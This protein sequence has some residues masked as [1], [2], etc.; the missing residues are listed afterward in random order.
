[1]LAV[2]FQQMW[3]LPYCISVVLVVQ[4]WGIFVKWLAFLLADEDTQDGVEFVQKLGKVLMN[5]FRKFANGDVYSQALIGY[6][7]CTQP[8][9]IRL[10]SRISSL[11]LPFIR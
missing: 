7:F 1:M 10:D 11:Y 3:L 9:V 6:L 8:M 5:E 2:L 4:I